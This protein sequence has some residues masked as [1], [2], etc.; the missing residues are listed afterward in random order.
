MRTL[1]SSVRPG[2]TVLAVGALL[3]GLMQGSPAQAAPDEL[4]DLPAVPGHSSTEAEPKPVQHNLSHPVIA[5]PLTAGESEAVIPKGDTAAI[6]TDTAKAD[7]SWQPIGNS[8]VRIGHATPL[9]RGSKSAPGATKVHVS[10][11]SSRDARKRTGSPIAI[12]IK[13]TDGTKATGPVAVEIPRDALESLYGADYSSRLRWVQ[14][15]SAKATSAASLAAASTPVS[16]TASKSSLVLTPQASNS[17]MILTAQSTGA[18]SNGSGD[19]T[20][21]PLNTAATWNVST[22]TGDFS[23]SYPIRTVPVAAGPQP[24]IALNY[25]SQSVDGETSATN[26]QSSSI[27][28]GWSLAGGGFIQR[29]YVPCSLDDGP[30]GPIASSGDLCWK[31]DNATLSIAGHAGQLAQ[32]GTTGEWRLQSDDGTRI[33]HTAG[34]PNCGSNGTWDTDCWVVTTT[35]GTRYFFG[36]RSASQ[37]AWTV[38]VFGNDPGEPCNTTSFCM[39]AWRWNLDQV[40]D[41][42]GNAE[43]YYYNAQNNIYSRK[44][45]T[46]TLYVRGGEL[47]HIDY[48]MNVSHITD[49]HAASATVSFTYDAYGR[50]DDATH[51]NCTSEPTAGF[52]TTP[53]HPADYPDVPFDQN[54]ITGTCSGL[55]SPTFWTVSALSSIT[56]TSWTGGIATKVDT[57]TLGHSY[58]D[59]KDGGAHSLWLARIDH[60]GNV[61]GTATEPPTLFTGTSMQNRVLTLTFSPLFKYRITTIATSLGS[62]ITVGYSSPDCQSSDVANVLANPWSNNRLCFPQQWVP[63]GNQPQTDLFHKYV[64]KQV[65]VTPGPSTPNVTNRTTSYSYGTPAWRYETSPLIPAKQRTWSRFAGFNQVTTLTGAPSAPAYQKRIDYTYYQGLNGDRANAAGGTKSVKV[66]G[67]SI[68]DDPWYAGTAYETK[69]SSGASGQAVSDTIKSSLWAS[70][71]TASDSFGIARMTGDAVTKLVVPSSNGQTTTTTSTVHDATFGYP[72]SIET[73]HDD[74]ASPSCVTTDYVNNTTAWV[75]GLV[76]HARSVAATCATPFSP[77]IA[78]SET[79]S[80]YDALGYGVTP[81]LGDV[82]ETSVVSS[83]DASNA[84]QYAITAKYAYDSMGRSVSSTDALS[85]TT[86][87]AY[88]PAAG[89]AEPG[90][91]TST[92]VSNTTAPVAWKTTTTYQPAWNVPTETSDQNAKITDISYDPLGRRTGIWLPGN[93]KTTNPSDPNTAYSYALSQ[94]VATYVATTTLKAASKVTTYNIYDGLGELVQTQAPNTAGKTTVTDY[95][96]DTQGNQNLVNNPYWTADVT[97]SGTLF[98]PNNTSNIPSATATQYDALGRPAAVMTLGY[99]IEKYRTTTAYPTA[100][101]TD[102][103]PPAGGTPTTTYVNSLGQRTSL[104]Q[105]QAANISASASKITTTYGYDNS[106]NLVRMSDQVGNTWTWNYDLLGHQTRATDPDTGA[107]ATTYDT[108]GNLISSTDARG[109]TLAYTYD[110]M[111]RKTAVYTDSTAGAIQAKWT[112]DSV[113]GAVGQLASATSYTGSTAGVPGAAYTASYTGY[114]SGYQPTGQTVSIPSAAPAFGGTSYS[115]SYQYNRDETVKA[116]LIPAMGGLGSEVLRYTYNGLG[117]LSGLSGTSN[118][119]TVTY[120][121]IG[122]LTSINRGVSVALNSGFGYD[123]TTGALNAKLE[124]ETNGTTVTTPASINYTRNAAGDITEAQNQTP[125]NTDTQCYQYD[126]LR[127]L[128]EAW[129]PGNNTCDTTGPGTS[130]ALGGPAPYWTSY[131]IDDVTGN[132]TGTAT[133]TSGGSITSSSTYSYPA[134]STSQPHAVSTVTTTG[135]GAGTNTYG[136]DAAGNTTVRPGQTLTWGP[137]GQLAT[138]AAGG[139]TQSNVYTADGE[140][141]LQSD[142]TTGSTLFVGETQ[143]H[144]APGSATATA[145]RDYTIA[146]H[147]VC[148]RVTIAGVSG[149]SLYYTAT[150]NNDSVYLVIDSATGGATQRYTDAFGNGRGP[151]ASWPSGNG[152]LNKPSDP[153]NGLV[154][155]GVRQYDASLGRFLTVDAILTVVNPGQNNGYTYSANNPVTNSDPSGKCYVGSNDSLNHNQNCSAGAGQPISHNNPAAKGPDNGTYSGTG[156]NRHGKAS[157]GGNHWNPKPAKVTPK[158]APCVF[159]YQ[160]CGGP[161]S[162]PP[163]HQDP[164]TFCG[165]MITECSGYGYVYDSP[166]TPDLS[167]EE[168]MDVFKKYPKDIFPFPVSGCA[169]FSNGASCH[170]DA[171]PIPDGSGDVNV[172]TSSTSVTFTVSSDGYFDPPGSTIQFSTLEYR[173]TVFLRRTAI[174]LPGG[175]PLVQIGVQTLHANE[176]VW[177]QQAANL[178]ALIEAGKR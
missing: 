137:L 132:R 25:D 54:C 59:P 16:V 94:T 112:Y 93:S 83:Y 10:V 90:S 85:H 75:I 57:W 160:A 159:S 122:Q 42:H 49:S 81:T 148:E 91:L 24:S 120:S 31:A 1:V 167:P 89:A 44:G 138:T 107:T 78:V 72:T 35:D 118:Y 127:N 32:I 18:S 80:A 146:D 135:P 95:G 141:L 70:A 30:T 153:F 104:V 115:F 111:N 134:A 96:Y 20:A 174:A 154:Q 63:P 4:P 73:T 76:A 98:T 169:E 58:P 15:P 100:D 40:V 114:D 177:D 21:T 38:P 7:G 77:S 27:G 2:L 92:V 105:Y 64:V 124:T 65:V 142:A 47:D 52:A 11:L 128:T 123:A 56:T 71:I 158:S 74:A 157:T 6:A 176:T 133:H 5:A 3:A 8:G 116:K 143:L 88:T 48:G 62:S 61:G 82:T 155:L 86:T 60:T 163:P 34:S 9:A 68:P 103:T 87:T 12:E 99:G 175:D 67:T 39:Q 43:V 150:D 172:A 129:T 119:G 66:T 113:T 22:Q 152:Y 106:G 102:V 69:V 36:S 136:Y 101:R 164:L 19:Y 109:T 41:V 144:L 131:A 168:V 55:L 79:R 29:N 147:T 178:R 166:I 140:L 13:R 151:A 97:P 26:N 125:A 170:L 162:P 145:V 33:Q 156:N 50:C 139:A 117:D 46:P 110:S 149:S 130:T 23:W 108:L 171:L 173:G 53:A 14:T 121:N 37:S 84:A 161:V 51:A 17:A 126:A 165:H 45:T 28:E